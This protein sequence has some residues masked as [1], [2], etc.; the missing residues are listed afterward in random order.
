MD[1]VILQASLVLLL[2]YRVNA[3]FCV[4][5][6][7]LFSLSFV[8]SLTVNHYAI[9][10]IVQCRNHFSSCIF[11]VE[12][13]CKC[14]SHHPAYLMPY[15]RRNRGH[16]RYALCLGLDKEFT[17]ENTPFVIETI[18]LRPTLKRIL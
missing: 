9:I 5:L 10:N 13:N 6:R 3:Y 4:L 15:A 18:F 8:S 14:D 12:Q 17:R 16:R 2:E 1:C 7:S 11:I